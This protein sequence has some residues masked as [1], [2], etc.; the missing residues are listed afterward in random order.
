MTEALDADAI[1]ADVARENGLETLP[2]GGIRE[3]FSRLI[4]SFNEQGR[5]APP[6]RP[7]ALAQIGGN[8][9]NRLELERDWARYPEILE[10]P[11]EQPVFVV[12]SP[13]TGTTILQCMLGQD[14]GSRIAYYWQT[15]NAAPPPGLAP[16][17]VAPRIAAESLNVRSMIDFIPHFLTAHPYL[18]Q[19]G[20]AEAEDED[21]FSIDFHCAFPQRYYRVP[22]L[23][24]WTP[25]TDPTSR[26]QF[27]KK[28]LQHLQWREPRKRWICKGT[29]HQFDLQS[30]WAVYPD[31]IC[32]WPHRDPVAFIGSLLELI[33]LIYRPINGLD[34][35]EFA[36]ATVNYLKM[37]Y[38][39][40]LAAPWLDDDRLLHVRFEDFMRDQLAVLHRVYDRLGVK[41]PAEFDHN[42]EA[43]LAN[44][45]NRSDRHG[46]F[47]YS[48]ERFGIRPAEIRESFATY[49]NRFG[50]A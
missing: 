38:D 27:H 44:P 20:L 9:R 10:Q 25:P 46:R 2:D 36:R 39:H 22:V 41:P 32:V 13:R 23:P 16:E 18:D 14:P 49:Y 7:A 45:A 42:V 40:V 35:N 8:L 1:I 48:L 4:G 47:K 21:I 50:L 26:F 43:W 12:G 11:I 30:L 33:Q 5:I 37:G 28:F 34:G 19:G 29:S 17:T 15:A 24:V 6:D 3:R 31:A